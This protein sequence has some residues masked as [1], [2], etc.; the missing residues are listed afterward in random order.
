LAIAISTA[1]TAAAITAAPTTLLLHVIQH[2]KR[3]PR[4]ARPLENAALDTPLRQPGELL[5]LQSGKRE[6][7]P[8]KTRYCPVRQTQ[9]VIA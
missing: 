5:D 4:F 6:N 1:T 3:D 2:L 8:S 9:R 7:S